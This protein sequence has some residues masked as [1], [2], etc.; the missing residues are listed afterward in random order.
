[1]NIRRFKEK[2]KSAL[3]PPFTLHPQPSRLNPQI[4]HPNAQTREELRKTESI[5]NGVTV[6]A[7]NR[8]GCWCEKGMTGVSGS[9]TYKT[10]FLKNGK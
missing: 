5:I 7:Y 4:Q 8:P 10:C 3:L 9:G 1:M 6:N 2:K